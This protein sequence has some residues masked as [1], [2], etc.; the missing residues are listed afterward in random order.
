MSNPEEQ[1]PDASN[2]DAPQPEPAPKPAEKRERI[3]ISANRIIIWIIVGG[4][5]LYTLITGIVGMLT[6]AR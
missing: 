5:G 2:P 4:I 1:T 3:P 6:K